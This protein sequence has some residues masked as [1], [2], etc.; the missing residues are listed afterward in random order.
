[1][2]KLKFFIQAWKQTKK[3]DG[4]RIFIYFKMIY[5][6]IIEGVSLE[7]FLFYDFY[8][9]NKKDR[10]KFV[11]GKENSMNID[12]FNDPNYIHILNDKDVFN[13]MFERYIGRD[14]LN[15]TK[16]S[17]NEY[18]QFIYK[19]RKIIIKPLNANRG[20]GIKVLDIEQDEDIITLE[21][22]EDLKKSNV[23]IENYITNHEK[24]AIFNKSSLN[25]IR[26]YT[27]LRDNNVN[28]ISAVLRTGRKNSSIDNFHAGGVA[29]SIDINSGII[30]SEGK[31]WPNNNKYD[32]HPDSNIKFKGT[33][34]PKWDEVI[35]L[36]KEISLL[37]PNLR[38]VAWD[39]AI[40]DNNVLVIEGNVRGD[41]IILQGIDLV[42]KRHRFK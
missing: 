15:V 32:F 23:L 3:I 12:K 36:V 2:N 41:K 4:I 11:L 37:I 29:A 39:I 35:S 5:L 30:N 1:M 18:L 13:N 34:I 8:R 21:Y 16:S 31:D 25:T 40:T 22:F 6:R 14:Y 9:K 24:L 10:E 17:F 42:G 20:L 28:I 27:L 19:H 38:Y 33:I 26:V 7:E